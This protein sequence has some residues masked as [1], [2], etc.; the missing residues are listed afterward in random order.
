MQSATRCVWPSRAA[1][2]HHIE[3]AMFEAVFRP[4]ISV[5]LVASNSCPDSARSTPAVHPLEGG[6]SEA[7]LLARPK[8]AFGILLISSLFLT[9]G[10]HWVVDAWVP[11]AWIARALDCVL[12]S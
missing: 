8:S 10:M 12:L 2:G 11:R 1:V 5:R 3:G 4:L 7:V 9:C 6:V